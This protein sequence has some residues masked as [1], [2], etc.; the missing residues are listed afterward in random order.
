MMQDSCSGMVWW[1][2]FSD[3]V[4]SAQG[5][6]NPEAEPSHRNGVGGAS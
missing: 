4:T 6:P 1:S 5:L 3:A 2:M